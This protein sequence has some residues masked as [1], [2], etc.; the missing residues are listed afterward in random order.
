LFKAKANNYASADDCLI[1]FF[2]KTNQ[3]IKNFTAAEAE[4]LVSVDP[5]YAT[6]DLYNAIANGNYPSWTTYIQVMTFAEAEKFR[7]NPF[8]LSKVTTS[9]PKLLSDFNFHSFVRSLRGLI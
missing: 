4:R 3:G 6:R 1:C 5:D 8:D 7:F 9:R 2:L